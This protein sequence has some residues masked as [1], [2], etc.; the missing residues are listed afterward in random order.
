MLAHHGCEGLKETVEPS[1]GFQTRDHRLARP[2]TQIE[3]F[4]RVMEG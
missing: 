1:A 2:E 4:Q 3:A